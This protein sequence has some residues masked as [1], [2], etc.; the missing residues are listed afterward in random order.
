MNRRQFMRNSAAA[1]A[2]AAAS[3]TAPAQNIITES[4]FT[5]LKWSKAPCRFCGTG[6]GVNLGGS[7]HD[8]RNGHP[9]DPGQRI[10]PAL[11]AAEGK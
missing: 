8:A 1:S 2:I 10:V 11:P 7:V 3:A 4:Q 5:K 9:R 6:C